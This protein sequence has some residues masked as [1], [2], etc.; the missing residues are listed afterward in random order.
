MR[1]EIG[2]F[3]DMTARR[4][5]KRL[6]LS[7]CCVFAG[8]FIARTCRDTESFI[9]CFVLVVAVATLVDYKWR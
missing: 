2:G 4:R 8:N 6:T 1:L 3:L 7:L 5:N 9:A